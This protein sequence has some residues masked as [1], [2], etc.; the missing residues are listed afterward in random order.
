MIWKLVTN[1]YRNCGLGKL[2][3]IIEIK[4]LRKQLYIDLVKRLFSTIYYTV[5][6]WIGWPETIDL[7]NLQIKRR[8][9]R[10]LWLLLWKPLFPSYIT[11]PSVTSTTWFYYALMQLVFTT[12]YI[13][14]SLRSLELRTAFSLFQ[15]TRLLSWLAILS[16]SKT[17]SSLLQYECKLLTEVQSYH[18]LNWVDMF[19]GDMHCMYIN[20]FT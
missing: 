11:Y 2:S 8:N 13:Y 20:A 16:L 3:A 14:S 17:K 4:T 6:N 12:I 7:G 5:K 10:F 9:C 1:Y 15:Y 19:F 18:P